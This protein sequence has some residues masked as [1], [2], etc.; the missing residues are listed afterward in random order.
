M[1]QGQPRVII[2]TTLVVL[3]YTMLHTKFQGHWSIGSGEE[4]FL[5]FLP[6]MGM[7]AMLVMWPRSFEQLFFPKGPGG[8]I[9]NLVAI[10]PVVSEE[11]SFEIVDGRRTDGRRTT[12]PAYTISSPGAFGSGE[13]KTIFT[14]VLLLFCEFKCCLLPYGSHNTSPLSSTAR[15][16]TKTEYR[17]IDPNR[18]KKVEADSHFWFALV[19]LK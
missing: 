15:E 16:W 12:E 13:L 6:Y 5:R 1:G 14:F 9:W 19:V 4:D 17:K 8:C 18:S 10:G 3:P 2:W 7:A 11:K